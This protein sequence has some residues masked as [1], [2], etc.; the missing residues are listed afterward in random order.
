[1]SGF[2]QKHCAPPYANRLPKSAN[3][4][5]LY[6]GSQDAWE[7]AKRANGCNVLVLPPGAQPSA[8][9][10]RCVAARSVVAVELEDTSPELRHAIVHT[11]AVY[12]AKDM[13]LI[14]HSQKAADC[15]LWNCGPARKEAA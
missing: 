10:W 12:G 9:D 13:Y 14:A 15:V 1:M 11:L 4:I 8:Y 6:L 2:Q 5:W 7:I 3:C